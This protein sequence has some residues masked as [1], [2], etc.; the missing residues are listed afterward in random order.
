M[1]KKL[2]CIILAICSVFLFSG[3]SKME[4]AQIIYPNGQIGEHI[5]VTINK[6]AIEKAGLDYEFVMDCVKEEI[7]NQLNNSIYNVIGV[8]ISS[9]KNLSTGTVTGQ[10]IFANYNVY[11]LVFGIDPNEESEKVIEKGFLYD[12]EI[13]SKHNL[14]YAT[15]NKEIIY[16][17]ITQR[18]QTLYPDV[19]FGFQDVDCYYSYAVPL[20]YAQVERIKTN[21]TYHY[22]KDYSNYSLRHFVWRY[23]HSNPNAQ[24][25]IYVNHIH[26]YAWYILGIGLTIIFMIVMLCVAL[27]KKAHPKITQEPQK[28]EL[29]QNKIN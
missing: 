25:V 8:T 14:V 20:A 9:E 3:C 23:D 2:L 7:D 12:R 13:L 19:P 5:G 27:I 1:S 26:S 15:Q 16:N 4:Y 11:C 10:I 17:N 6:T 21:A 18:L 29:E 22:D 28:I 24:A